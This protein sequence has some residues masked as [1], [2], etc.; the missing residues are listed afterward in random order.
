MSF[1]LCEPLSKMGAAAPEGVTG[2]RLCAED[3][4]RDLQRVTDRTLID[5]R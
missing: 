1:F 2:P 5:K 4:E 3:V